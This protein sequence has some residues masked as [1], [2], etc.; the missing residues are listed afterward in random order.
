MYSCTL[1]QVKSAVT[2]RY[3]EKKIIHNLF[4]APGVFSKLP[5]ANH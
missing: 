5:R 2:M 1:H 3:F 4:I